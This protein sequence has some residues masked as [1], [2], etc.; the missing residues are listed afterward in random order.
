MQ[1]LR[2]RERSSSTSVPEVR[3]FDVGA[4]RP[5]HGEPLRIAVK[6][7]LV[8]SVVR[9]KELKDGGPNHVESDIGGAMLMANFM[10]NTRN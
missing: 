9:T 5:R 1:I 6:L 2:E 10:P 4:L 7:R 3:T 8:D